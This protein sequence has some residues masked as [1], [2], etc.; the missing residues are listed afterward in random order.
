MQL[1]QVPYMSVPASA[2][3]S[4]QP[5]PNAGRGLVAKESVAETILLLESDPPVA[6]VIFR[7]YR[8]EVCAKC[9]HYDEGRTLPVRDQETGKFFCSRSCQEAWIQRTGAVGRAVWKALQEFVQARRKAL[10]STYNVLPTGSKP[11]V[12]SVKSAWR[13]AEAEVNRLRAASAAKKRLA[14][15]WTELVDPDVL[16][17]LLSG[18]VSLSRTPQRLDEV[19]ALAMDETPYKSAEDLVT[20]CQAYAQLASILPPEVQDYCT[21]DIC[22]VLIKGGSHN[23]FGIRAGSEDG[24]EYVGYGLFPTASYF[25]HSCDPNV[26]KQ[27]MGEC[28]SFRANRDVGV[29]E[30]CCI[31]YLGGDEKDLNVSERRARLQDAW[32]FICACERCKGEQ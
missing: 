20:H 16:G 13:A 2:L 6:H 7:Q 28:W 22:Q 29:G 11:D 4:V 17:Y 12:V 19:R 9:F 8:K 21:S 25:N 31:S 10:Y 24:E 32:G 26:A 1:P 3:F 5:I 15:Q 23:A 30:Q 27:R 18:I 14:Q